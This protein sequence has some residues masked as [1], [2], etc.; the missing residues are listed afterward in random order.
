MTTKTKSKPNKGMINMD[1]IGKLANPDAFKS[2]LKLN[3]TPEFNQHGDNI[4]PVIQEILIYEIDEYSFNPRQAENDHFL[5]IKQ[6]IEEVGLQQRFSVTRNPETQRYMLCKGGNTRLKAFKMLWKETGDPKFEKIE[7]VVEPWDGELN[8][9]Q[10]VIAHLVENEARGELILVDKAKALIQLEQEYKDYGIKSL[11]SGQTKLEKPNIKNITTQEFVD[12]L[13]E[14]GYSVSEKQLGL[15][16]FTVQRLV[17]NLDNFLDQGLGSP[18]IIKIR[19]VYNNLKR[20]VKEGEYDDYGI[21]ALNDDFSIV[22]KKYNKTKKSFD[23]ER[24]LDVLVLQ[25]SGQYP[26]NVFAD[27]KDA[28]KVALLSAKPSKKVKANAKEKDKADSKDATDGNIK[29]LGI[30][31]NDKDGKEMA[32]AVSPLTTADSSSS[33]TNNLGDEPSNN[34]SAA[35]LDFYRKQ[36]INLVNKIT[37]KLNI[38]YVVHHTH[39]GCGFLLVDVI[40]PNSKNNFE[41]WGVWWLLLG[42]SHA[43]DLLNPI[44]DLNAAGLVDVEIHNEITELYGSASLGDAEG[45]DKSFVRINT[46]AELY[47]YRS[48]NLQAVKDRLVPH[49]W[50]D[51]TELEAIC[52]QIMRIASGELWS[53]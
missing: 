14:N 11:T 21:D 25:L 51:L 35:H 23:F 12:F 53:E 29:E 42:Y 24:L 7:C 39:L 2:D 17:G 40:H 38:N 5:D 44:I 34:G 36:A 43:A 19:S 32:E 15:F 13:K 8:K 20:I 27:D 31:A 48:P 1:D 52:Y 50:Q 30:E 18:Q 41:N 10:A 28:L 3:A 33:T 46:L 9:T 26:F 16:R 22:I 6:S 37:N 4:N 49:M 45:V 47:E